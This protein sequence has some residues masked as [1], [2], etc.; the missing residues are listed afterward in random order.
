MKFYN[1]WYPIGNYYIRE[2]ISSE[3]IGSQDKNRFNSG[4]QIFLIRFTA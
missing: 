4:F 3:I 1:T 2:D